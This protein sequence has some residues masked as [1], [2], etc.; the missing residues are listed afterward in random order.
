[1]HDM[2]RRSGVRRQ[3]DDVLGAVGP[4]VGVHV[5]GRPHLARDGHR[6]EEFLVGGGRRVREAESHRGRPLVQAL[7]DASRDLVDLLGRGKVVLAGV[8]GQEV[9]RVTHHTHAHRD[10]ADARAVVHGLAALAF[11]VEG[12]DVPRAD[13]ELQSCGHPVMRHETV[14]L[15]GLAVLVQVDEARRDHEARCVDHPA[16]GQRFLR[17]RLDAVARD[18]DVER[19][20]R[21]GF[22]VHDPAS[23]KHHIVDG[24]VI[25]ACRCPE[26]QDETD[27]CEQ[28]PNETGACRR[29]PRETRGCGRRPDRHPC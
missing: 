9:A 27:G 22:G 25:R 6:G 4:P 21:S 20:V 2:E 7:A 8:R 12:G 18:A 29:P 19:R 11:G 3:V 1:M 23:R 24:G 5:R 15:V 10:M 26:D 16:A 17:D 14:G 13:L 28:S